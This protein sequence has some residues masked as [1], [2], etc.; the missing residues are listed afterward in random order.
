MLQMVR[1]KEGIFKETE[2]VVWVPE[3]VSSEETGKIIVVL[4]IFQVVEAVCDNFINE[5]IDKFQ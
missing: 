1:K 5:K 3:Q 2:G 4:M